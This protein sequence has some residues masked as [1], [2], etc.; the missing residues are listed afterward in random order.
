MQKPEEAKKLKKYALD[1]TRVRMLNIL[2]NSELNLSPTNAAA[3]HSAITD[4]RTPVV[5]CMY[6]TE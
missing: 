2:L 3:F 4:S 5:K 1:L 6:S